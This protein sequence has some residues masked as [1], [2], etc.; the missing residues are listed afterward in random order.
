MWWTVRIGSE[1][2]AAVV[3]EWSGG[4]VVRCSAAVRPASCSSAAPT[5]RAPPASSA[6]DALTHAR[7]RERG[8]EGR[9]W[10]QRWRCAVLC[11]DMVCCVLCVCDV[12]MLCICSGVN[13]CA[14]SVCCMSCCSSRSSVSCCCLSAASVCLSVTLM[15][16]ACRCC[17]T[18]RM[19]DSNLSTS[20]AYSAF[21]CRSTAQLTPA[22]R[23]ADN[24]DSNEDRSDSRRTTSALALACRTPAP[25]RHTS[26]N[27]RS[28]GRTQ[29]EQQITSVGA[30]DGRR[31]SSSCG[32]ACW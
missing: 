7:E 29:R 11:C 25:P 2:E 13:S 5:P 14:A 30:G 26:S 16:T 10:L 18:S 28:V 23:M 24:S 31:G 15:R 22:A 27:T 19:S 21:F 20:D 6:A 1:G 32:A 3:V 9:R 12:L 4:E 17:V 8:G